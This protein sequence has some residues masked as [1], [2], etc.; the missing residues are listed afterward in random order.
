MIFP[1]HFI[2][3]EF[4]NKFKRIMFQAYPYVTN[5]D[6]NNKSPFGVY[7]LN[8]LT[9]FDLKSNELKKLFYESRIEIA[10][11]CFNDNYLDFYPNELKI[12][13]CIN[14][15]THKYLGKY[16]TFRKVFFGNS[17]YNIFIDS[18]A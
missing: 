2:S 5:T 7:L 11:K 6:E 12:E 14:N 8:Y 18:Y 15:T 3:E 17:I 10:E 4:E 13:Q 1:K 9:M 16:F